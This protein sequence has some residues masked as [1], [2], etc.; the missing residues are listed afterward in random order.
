LIISDDLDEL[1][2]CG[3]VLVLFKGRLVA[4]FGSQWR[5]EDLVAAIEGI[6]HDAAERELQ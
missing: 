1:V 3:R 5:D 4:E 2:I 6:R